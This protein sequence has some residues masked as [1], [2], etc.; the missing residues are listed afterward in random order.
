[1]Y[2]LLR[3]SLAIMSMAISVSLALEARWESLTLLWPIALLHLL[4][5]GLQLLALLQLQ[6]K[7]SGLALQPPVFLRGKE[8]P[9]SGQGTPSHRPPHQVSPHL[10][11]RE[12]ELGVSVGE[13]EGV[14]SPLV[15][16]LKPGQFEEHVHG[17]DGG[18]LQGTGQ[19]EK[20][21][22]VHGLVLGSLRGGGGGWGVGKISLG[23]LTVF[24]RVAEN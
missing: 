19:E 23:W 16:P 1:M 24:L 22:Q 15:L 7:L 11:L 9:E 10:L 17:L 13:R 4:L 21:A 6:V 14:L 5:P 3:M 2:M 18:V 8:L 20:V 12:E